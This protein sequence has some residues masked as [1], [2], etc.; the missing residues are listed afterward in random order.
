MSMRF[1]SCCKELIKIL[2]KYFNGKSSCFFSLTGTFVQKSSSNSISYIKYT[3]TE[4]CDL[5]E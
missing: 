4:Y 1:A 3:T 2:K 5:A